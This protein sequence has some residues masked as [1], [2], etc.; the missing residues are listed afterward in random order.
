VKISGMTPREELPPEVESR[1]YYRQAPWKRIVVIAAGPGMNVVIAFVLLWVVLA[2]QGIP[3][4]PTTK[5]EQVEIGSPADGRL[6]PGDRIL[7][8]DGVDGGVAA[9][10][11]QIGRHRCPGAQKGGCRATTPATVVVERHG[12][13]STLLIT[14]R[15][16]AVAKRARLG[17]GFGTDYRSIG[18][19]EAVSQTFSGMWRITKGTVSAITRLFYSSKARKDVS[20]ITVSYEATRRSFASDWGQTLDLLA[21]I[22]L[23]LAIVNAFPFL[24][25]DGGHI[26]WAL[27]EKVRGRP[28]PFSVLE[29]A[30]VVGIML[31]GLLFIIGLSNDIGRIT[32][33]EGFGVR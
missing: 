22:S 16:D 6:Q 28:I 30:S 14:P 24:P 32:S 1:A 27:A 17:F 9:L 2:F 25:L 23:S 8:V 7:T 11:R 5:V 13:R 10:G 12:R 4:K 20:G 29:R 3:D 26:F 18:A 19:G 31:V 33:G 21:I 15:Y